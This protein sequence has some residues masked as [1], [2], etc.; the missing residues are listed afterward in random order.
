M[1]KKDFTRMRGMKKMYLI[2]RLVNSEFKLRLSH[3]K[4]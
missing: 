1:R 4:G 2:I 3:Q